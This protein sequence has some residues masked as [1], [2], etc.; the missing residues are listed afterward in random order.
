[1]QFSTCTGLK[2]DQLEC[3]VQK[4]LGGGAAMRC[5]THIDVAPTFS[6]SPEIDKFLSLQTVK[7]GNWFTGEARKWLQIFYSR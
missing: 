4:S 2:I 3:N 1:M 6:Y 5:V 7:A